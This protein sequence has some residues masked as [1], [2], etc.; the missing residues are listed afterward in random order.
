M[1]ED[2]PDAE[3]DAEEIASQIAEL[4]AQLSEMQ[5]VTEEPE[6]PE[7]EENAEE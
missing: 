1:I 2:Q 3:L 6:E 7:Q 4:R 5:F